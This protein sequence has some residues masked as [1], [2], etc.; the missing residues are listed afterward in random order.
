[1][2]A[3]IVIQARLGSNRLPGK[4]LL[5]LLGGQTTILRE[6]VERSHRVKGSTNAIVAIPDSTRDDD[7]ADYVVEVLPTTGMTR[8]SEDDALERFCVAA[9]AHGL[10]HVVRLT[11]DNPCIDPDVVEQALAAH[12]NGRY[13]YTCTTGLPMGLNVE[14]VTTSA[15]LKANR[16]E[17][18][19]TDRTHV[20]S[21]IRN[22]P[23]E[24]LLHWC[25]VHLAAD[26]THL[27]LTVDT[28]LDYVMVQILFDYLASEHRNFG[29]RQILKLREE[30]PFIFEIN[31]HIHQKQVF[32]TEEL[33]LSEALELLQQQEL[34]RAVD[35]LE[36]YI[37]TCSGDGNRCGGE[38]TDKSDSN[39]SV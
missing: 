23:D 35:V 19:P 9:R 4:V 38:R 32:A 37:T 34:F 26:A 22:R 29:V 25:P 11:A 31:Q 39:L 28:Y 21:Y 10:E 14:V 1:M 16:S 15:L 33:E 27:R 24:F 20:T 13:D 18:S 5:P 12:I 30:R 17:C 2:T 3:G 8:G 7:L 6:I 36:N